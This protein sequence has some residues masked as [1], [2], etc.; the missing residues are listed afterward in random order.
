[1]AVLTFNDRISL[2][3]AKEIDAQ[4]ERKRDV[5]ENGNLE[6]SEYKFH[7]GFIKGLREARKLIAAADDEAMKS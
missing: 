4:I 7:V 2:L 6:N 3:A 5:L 1:M